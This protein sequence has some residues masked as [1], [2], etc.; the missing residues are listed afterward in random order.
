MLRQRI[1][2]HR[3]SLKTA[4]IQLTV[5]ITPTVAVH[6]R[7]DVQINANSRGLSARVRVTYGT[8]VYTVGESFTKEARRC[9]SPV[10]SCATFNPTRICIR[11]PVPKSKTIRDYLEIRTTVTA[12]NIYLKTALLSKTKVIL[13]NG[14]EI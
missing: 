3:Y 5:Q 1:R 8:R 10:T 14:R 6:D 13:I 12:V 9:L 2:R 4:H 11:N 7:F